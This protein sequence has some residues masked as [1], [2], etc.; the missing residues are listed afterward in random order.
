MSSAQEFLSEKKFTFQTT[1]TSTPKNRSFA[2]KILCYENH[3][4]VCIFDS[5][6]ERIDLIVSLEECSREAKLIW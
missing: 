6:R 3:L 4:G 5:S 1:K 2:V